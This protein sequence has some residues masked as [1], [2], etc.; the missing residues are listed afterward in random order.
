MTIRMYV[1]NLA[2]SVERWEKVAADA[3]AAGVDLTRIEGVDGAAIDP[4]AWEDVDFSVFNKWQGRRIL[5]GE[6]GCYRSHLKAL[7]AVANGDDQFALIAE[8]D[9]G[10]DPDFAARVEALAAAAPDVEIMRL[11]SHRAVDF[12]SFGRSALGDEF[13]R[14]GIGPQGSAACYLVTRTAA[15]K[16]L[17][18]LRV[19][20]LP[21]DV[22]LERSWAHGV[23]LLSVKTNIVRLTSGEHD[24]LIATS[25]DYARAKPSTLLRSRTLFFRF[26]ELIR[27]AAWLNDR[28]GMAFV[29]GPAA[30]LTGAD[31]VSPVT[32]VEWSR[33][34]FGV[35]AMMLVL[36]A[37]WVE[38]DAYRIGAGFFVVIAGFG[39]ALHE[40]RP[41]LGWMAWLCFAW[42]AW[43]AAR[44]GYDHFLGGVEDW[45]S[46]EGVYLL[47]ALYPVVGYA[48]FLIRG[49]RMLIDMIFIATS[50]LMLIVSIKLYNLYTG[51]LPI[52]MFHN[53]Q[54]HGAL[55]TGFLLIYAFASFPNAFQ[56]GVRWRKP[57]LVAL[58]TFAALCLLHVVGARSRGVWI[59]LALAGAVQLSIA[60]ANMDGKIRRRIAFSAV[61]AAIVLVFVAW[62]VFSGRMAPLLALA[63]RVAQEIGSGGFDG[64]AI[65]AVLLDTSLDQS[66]R[67]R[68]ALWVNA[69]RIWSSD[70]LFGAGIAWEQMLA[71][72]ARY[73]TPFNIFHNGYL[74]IAVRHGLV[75][76][77]FFFLLFGWIA[78]Q[79]RKAR[80]VGII[81]NHVYAAAVAM[82][83]LYLTSLLTNSNNRLAL[84]EAFGL[85]MGSSAFALAY[86]RERLRRRAAGGGASYGPAASNA[87]K[88]APEIALDHRTVA[89]PPISGYG[90]AKTAENA[91]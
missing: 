42:A 6:Y 26:A 21:Y 68:L 16:L 9:I 18:E 88:P 29:D 67:I 69:I 1:I 50:I 8:D 41:R 76:L 54:I 11:V 91:P 49:R 56:I 15:R 30:V 19:M 2:R 38:T 90:D 71:Q 78:V 66:A 7:Q 86:W 77:V 48:I 52:P 72:H 35:L 79:F 36:S 55:A 28:R 25:S 4:A 83:A 22:A 12:L 70:Y 80:D 17:D 84:G 73:S 51:K 74:E 58:I 37:L 53:N 59:A 10:I 46:A 13:G 85:F 62:P 57:V 75:G 64:A 5:P 63:Q 60:S 61:S 47:P 27:R 32:W 34:G 14:C 31:A 65:D 39:V 82:I 33:S 24:S 81:G 40:F 87:A 20:R 3:V 89:H 44:I 43:V 45:G 23:D